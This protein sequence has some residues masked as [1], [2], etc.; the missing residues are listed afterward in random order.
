MG[1]DLKQKYKRTLANS[2]LLFNF[3]HPFIFAAVV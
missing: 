1:S 2:S 3:G